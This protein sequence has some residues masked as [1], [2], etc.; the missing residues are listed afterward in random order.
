MDLFIGEED[1]LNQGIGTQAITSFTYMLFSDFKATSIVVD[2][3]PVNQR[4]LNCYKKV[5]F[6]LESE[7]D[8]PEGAALILRLRKRIK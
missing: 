8:T 2:V 4:A 1:Q 3:N 6:V 5:G 7:R